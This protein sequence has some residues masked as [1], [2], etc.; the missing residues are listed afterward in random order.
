MERIANYIKIISQY[1][2]ASLIPMVLNLAINPLV[3]IYMEP[4]DFAITGYFL[5]F[6]SLVSPII[7]FYLIHYYNK[8]YFE[9]DENGREHMRALIFKMLI[10]FSAIVTII[11]TVAIYLYIKS[12]P[13]IHFES[14]PYLYMVMLVIPLTGIYNLQLAQYKMERKSKQYMNLSVTKGII[15][16]IFTL[17]F[18]VIIPWR[19]FGKLLGPMLIE[20]A[21]FTYILYLNKDIWKVKNSLSEIKPVLLFCWPLVV[22]ASLGYFS[23]GYDKAIL[24]TLGNDTEFGYYCV[25]GSIAGYLSLFTASLS[26]TFQPDIYEAIIKNNKSKLI[27]VAFLRWGL[28]LLI[29]IMF[30]VFCPL[31]IKILTAGRYMQATGY[32]RLLACVCLVN[33][34]YYIINDYTIARGLPKFYL[35]TTVIGTGLI[36]ICMP[37]FVNWLGYYGGALANIASFITLALINIILL[38]IYNLVK[39]NTIIK[40]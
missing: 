29:V 25:G 28:T 4:E 18:V 35:Y 16:T 8:C 3:A 19:A 13:E 32:A 2:T 11:C 37:I 20:I 21:F 10:F 27:K 17:L 39:K 22:G 6:T 5:S 36:I 15:G 24:A 30:I 26:A 34:I 12:H 33:C 14:Y 23:N 31:I 38:I 40:L 1:F 9:L 7:A